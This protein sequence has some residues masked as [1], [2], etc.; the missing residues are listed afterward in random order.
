MQG[1]GG[2]RFRLVLNSELYEGLRYGWIHVYGPQGSSSSSS[3]NGP[4]IKAG[5]VHAPVHFSIAN[6]TAVCQVLPVNYEDN[7]FETA[8]GAVPAG[9]PAGA[10]A[11]TFAEVWHTAL[12][13]T[14]VDILEPPAL[15]GSILMD[16][17]DRISWPVSEIRTKPFPPRI[18]ARGH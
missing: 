17:G 18:S 11:A 6:W 14:R 8:G 5:T 13:T 10:G 15:F 3:S 9:S 4:A 7:A 16:R 2:T 1:L 12:Y